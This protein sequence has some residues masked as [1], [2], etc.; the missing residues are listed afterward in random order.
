MIEATEVAMAQT[1]TTPT[2][3]RSLVAGR[4]LPPPSNLQVAHTQLIARLLSLRVPRI[5]GDADGPDVRALGDYAIEVAD[6]VDVLVEAIGRE[7]RSHAPAGC[8]VDLD[9]FRRQLFKALEGNALFEIS[10]VADAIEESQ[11]V[12]VK[13]WVPSEAAE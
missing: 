5:V 2:S 1:D 4:N 12:A 8:P 7:T 6:A 10:E 13:M 11:G 3:I 9:L